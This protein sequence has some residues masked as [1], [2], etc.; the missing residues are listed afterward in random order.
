MR[1]N[2][3]L[4]KYNIQLKSQRSRSAVRKWKVECFKYLRFIFYNNITNTIC[5]EIFIIH[6]IFEVDKYQLKSLKKLSILRLC[7]KLFELL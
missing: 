2:N 6:E 1:N 4:V 5:K 3:V 7:T